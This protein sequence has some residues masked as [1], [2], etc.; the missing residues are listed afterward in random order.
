MSA[1]TKFAIIAAVLLSPILFLAYHGMTRE[2]PALPKIGFVIAILVALLGLGG[3]L[4][5]ITS[6]AM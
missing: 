1:T 6:G 5:L 2:D 3:G 4:L